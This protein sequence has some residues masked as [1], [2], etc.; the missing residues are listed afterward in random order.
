MVKLPMNI[1]M[2]IDQKLRCTVYLKL[3]WNVFTIICKLILLSMIA[4]VSFSVI[5]KLS[6]KNVEIAFNSCLSLGISSQQTCKPRLLL[7]LKLVW[8][9]ICS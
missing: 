6:F 9:Y 5:V 2:A 8:I 1:D 7:V 3:Y 4:N